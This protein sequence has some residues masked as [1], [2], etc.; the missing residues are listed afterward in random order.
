MRYVRAAERLQ[1]R[2][3][4]PGAR[5][6]HCGQVG[7]RGRSRRRLA[8]HPRLTLNA[9]PDRPAGSSPRAE[10]PAPTSPAPGSTADA[11]AA[12][13]P[14]RPPSA[15]PPRGAWSARTRHTPSR[16]CDRAPYQRGS[17]PC[18]A[19]R[20]SSSLGRNSSITPAGAPGC[21]AAPGPARARP[22]SERPCDASSPQARRRPAQPRQVIRLQ[23]VHDLLGRLHVVPFPGTANRS[24]HHQ[25]NRE[26]APTAEPAGNDRI[27]SGR[28]HGRHRAILMSASGQLSGRLRAVS[29]GRRQTL[30]ALRL[31]MCSVA[32]S[33]SAVASP[34]P[35]EVTG[36]EPEQVGLFAC[37]LHGMTS[38]RP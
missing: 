35:A 31:A 3:R 21:R 33:Q 1:P 5:T 29:R 9:E 12:G 2:A 26:G 34:A 10:P 28:S 24:W 37:V 15:A 38:S 20:A 23:N 17:S 13:P 7:S 8:A 11:P 19:R 16:R 32:F 27:V 22:H 36:S 30:A 6:Y 4:P 18:S 25:P 14:A